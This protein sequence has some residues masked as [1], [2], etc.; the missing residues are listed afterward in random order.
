M[1]SRLKHALFVAGE[2]QSG[3][4]RRLGINRATVHRWVT[5]EGVLMMSLRQAERVASALGCKIKDLF[6]E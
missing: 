2:T 5:D 6:E 1:K 3:L 4:A